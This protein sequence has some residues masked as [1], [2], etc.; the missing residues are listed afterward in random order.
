VEFA[1]SS[2]KFPCSN[3]FFLPPPEPSHEEKERIIK[4]ITA[5]IRRNV[6]NCDSVNARTPL[7]TAI[8]H[9]HQGVIELLI[10]SQ[11]VQLDK[12]HIRSIA[13]GNNDNVRR[14]AYFYPLSIACYYGEPGCVRLL[15]QANNVPNKPALHAININQ[16]SDA[17]YCD[18]LTPYHW[19]LRRDN[20][21]SRTYQGY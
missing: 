13:K 10:Q 17:N 14:N 4:E 8:S 5:A 20:E 7:F 6:Y 9:G 18:S 11:Q 15:M 12:P 16:T 3:I 19:A 21:K 1:A 2:P